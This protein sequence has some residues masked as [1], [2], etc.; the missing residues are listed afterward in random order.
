MGAQSERQNGQGRHF[1][2]KSTPA[3]P[4][5]RNRAAN[6]SRQ[7]DYRSF[8][9]DFNRPVHQPSKVASKFLSIQDLQH[10]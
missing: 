10:D 2:Y 9:G 8:F 6:P 7:E 5:T 3:Q 4:A 1:V